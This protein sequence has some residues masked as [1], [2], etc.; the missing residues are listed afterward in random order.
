MAMAISTYWKGEF[1][2]LTS[3]HPQAGVNNSLNVEDLFQL[4]K[5]RVRS[6]AWTPVPHLRSIPN[7]D[8]WVSL[9]TPSSRVCKQPKPICAYRKLDFF[10]EHVNTHEMV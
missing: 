3:K 2:N 9:P 8:L 5:P 10:V 7:P 1:P 6:R 4:P